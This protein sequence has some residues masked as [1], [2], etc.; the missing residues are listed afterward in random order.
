MLAIVFLAIL[1][2]IEINCPTSKR[3]FAVFDIPISIAISVVELEASND[4]RRS[5]DDGLCVWCGGSVFSITIVIRGHRVERVGMPFVAVISCRNGRDIIL[6]KGGSATIYRDEDV[7][8]R[9]AASLGAIIARPGDEEIQFTHR[10]ERDDGTVWRID[11][12]DDSV[13]DPLIALR[14]TAGI[15]RLIFDFRSVHSQL[16][17]ARQMR[18]ATQAADDESSWITR[19]RQDANGVCDQVRSAVASQ[20]QIVEI[21]GVRIDSLGELNL[22]GR[23]SR[24]ARIGRHID[25]IGDHGSREIDGPSSCGDSR[26][27]NRSEVL[28]SC[29]ID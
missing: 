7:K 8:E 20:L 3:F 6:P 29:S 10:R 16:I 24:V 15:T 5:G 17:T 25:N 28:D 11:V 2:L 1:I 9:D 18:Q 12:D 19:H 4:P 23:H 21:E 13:V 22:D 26:S 14:A 27:R